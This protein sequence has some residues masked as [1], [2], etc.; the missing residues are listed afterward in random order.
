MVRPGALLSPLDQLSPPVVTRAL[1]CPLSELASGFPP[2]ACVSVGWNPSCV[3]TDLGPRFLRNLC[4]CPLPRHRRHQALC[5]P[6]AGPGNAAHA[7]HSKPD[8]EVCLGMVRER[9]GHLEFKGTV[10]LA[11]LVF[12]SVEGLGSELSKIK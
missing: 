4:P 3:S 7:Q 2:G 5:S 11:T 10:L 1:L 9:R 12:F 8:G 6:S